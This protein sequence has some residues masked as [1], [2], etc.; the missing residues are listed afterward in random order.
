MKEF[1][2]YASDL[3]HKFDRK[4]CVRFMDDLVEFFDVMRHNPAVWKDDDSVKNALISISNIV[5][6]AISGKERQGYITQ[7]ADKI[8][9]YHPRHPLTRGYFTETSG[10]GKGILS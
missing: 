4:L 2:L 1:S 8:N 3:S 5:N 10:P 9:P 6:N 7:A